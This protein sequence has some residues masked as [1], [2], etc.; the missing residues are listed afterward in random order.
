M[1]IKRIEAESGCF[2]KA[3]PDEPLFVLRAQDALAPNI[4]RSWASLAEQQ[5]TP[6]EK[7]REARELADQMEAWHT[8]KIPD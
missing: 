5:G 3:H 6:P 7:V 2:S 1:G 8:T 4:V